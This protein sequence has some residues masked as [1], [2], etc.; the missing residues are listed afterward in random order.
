MDGID[1][2]SLKAALEKIAGPVKEIEIVRH[3]NYAFVEFERSESAQRAI[4]QSLPLTPGGRGGILCGDFRVTVE[5][6]KDPG[7]RQ[8]NRS[9]GGGP[10]Q[11]LNGGGR[12]G[13]RGRGGTRGR[14]GPPKNL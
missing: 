2:K 13:Y 12:G 9:R 6:K 14:G 4:S 3:K 10:G 1:E 5:I 8:V 7:E 11:G